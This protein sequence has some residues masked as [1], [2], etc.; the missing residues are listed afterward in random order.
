MYNLSGQKYWC[1]LRHENTTIKDG[2]N[3][4]NKQRTDQDINSLEKTMTSNK[5]FVCYGLISTAEIG[6]NAHIPAG[7]KSMNSEIIS[8]SSRNAS[9]AESTAKQYGIQKWFPSYQE[10]ITDPDIDAVINVLPNSLHCEW[11]IKAAESGKHI[12]CEKPL[13]LS[14]KECQRMI[15]AANINNVLLVEAFTHRWNPHLRKARELISKGTIGTIVTIDASLNFPA[16]PKNN[17]RFSNSLGGG[18]LWDVGCYVV[19]AARYVLAAEP[20]RVHGVSHDS[21]NWGVDTTFCGLMQFESGAIANITGSME[22]LFLCHISINGSNGRIEIP[23]MFDDSGP[24]IITTVDCYDCKTEQTITVPAPDRFMVQL[25]EFSDCILA[26]KH[27]EFPAYD[28]LKNTAI[29]QA[30]YKSA[31]S[32][33]AV[34]IKFPE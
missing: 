25:D 27:P 15:D 29:L 12:L 2:Y 32:G 13:G 6:L 22:E 23:N 30:L 20:I 28:G 8:I 33:Q 9:K 10:Q 31:H 34:D 19:Y 16:K 24:I 21:G 3:N 18:A 5:D 1:H 17:I 4:V 7:K 14:I 26:D 11:S